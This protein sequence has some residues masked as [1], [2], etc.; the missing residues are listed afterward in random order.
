MHK[1]LFDLQ[2]TFFL[3]PSHYRI[4][5]NWEFTRHVQ[6]IWKQIQGTQRKLI[7]L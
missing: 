2:V 3:H 4:P 1:D 5:H 7:G 6:G